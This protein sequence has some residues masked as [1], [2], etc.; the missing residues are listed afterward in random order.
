[1]HVL[2]AI[3]L[4]IAAAS[5]L[6]AAPVDS[7][8]DMDISNKIYYLDYP[9]KVFTRIARIRLWYFGWLV[10]E[11]KYPS[12]DTFMYLLKECIRDF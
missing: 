3:F 5:S 11:V 4:V 8:L 10:S 2:V 12:Y 7:H 9:S 6:N 1:M